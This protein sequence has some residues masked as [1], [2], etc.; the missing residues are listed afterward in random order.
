MGEGDRFCTSCGTAASVPAGASGRDRRLVRPMYE[1]WIAGVCAG[2]ARY[3]GLDPT[4]VRLLW[5]AAIIL[6]G[7]GF[8]AYAIAW[9]VMP[10]DYTRPYQAP[11]VVGDQ[12]RAAS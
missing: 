11:V 5:L 6:Y 9:I 3:L 2:V 10:A 4:L 8:L 1:K 7:T 12:G